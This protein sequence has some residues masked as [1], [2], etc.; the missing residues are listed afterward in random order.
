MEA[1]FTDNSWSSSYAPIGSAQ[2]LD[3]S[4][5]GNGFY[6]SDVLS[7]TGMFDAATYFEG[8]QKLPG[9]PQL[10]G[11]IAVF[12]DPIRKTV[13]LGNVAKFTLEQNQKVKQAYL[14]LGFELENVIDQLSLSYQQ[15]ALLIAG[16]KIVSSIL[17][18]KQVSGDLGIS[19]E[20]VDKMISS[21][22]GKI[23]VGDIEEYFIHVTPFKEVDL[24]ICLLTPVDVEYKFLKDFQNKSEE[25]VIRTTINRDLV[26]FIGIVIMIIS[27]F[28]VVGQNTKPIIAIAFAA[29]AVQKG[30]L[31]DAVLPDLHL[32]KNNE[33]QILHDAFKDMIE[34]LK[35]KERV[36]GILDKVVS[37]DIAEEILKQGIKLGGEERKVT[38]FFADIR[39]FTKMTQK[40]DPSEVIKML[41]VCMTK[42]SNVIERY[43]GVIDKYVGDE[44][45][46]LFGAP[47]EREDATIEAIKCGLEV[48]LVLKEWNELRKKENLPEILM[49]IGIHTGLVFAGNMGAENRL[50]Y[51]VIGNNVNLTARL[52]AAAGPGEILISADVLKE[53]D[54]AD[55][56][57]TYDMGPMQ[58]KGYERGSTGL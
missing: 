43:H 50:N 52:C 28:A 12:L 47:V 45:M 7:Q 1:G 21:K 5:K 10:A 14:T 51:T 31:N 17:P 35:E 30:K 44:V 32:G 29:R 34:G 42:L 16:N 4:T 56:V 33:V 23:K 40:M 54:V 37:E 8:S 36:K 38:I 19:Q 9:Q 15:T 13:Y 20:D 11:N 48:M 49:G 53:K 6:V 18:G 46:V 58:L 2:F 3:D 24:S 39:G 55:H 27:V 26:I 22:Q 57:A 25:L 41:N